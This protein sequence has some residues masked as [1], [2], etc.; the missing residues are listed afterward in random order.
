[1]EGAAGASFAPSE[2]IAFFR[3]AR[4][5]FALHA[6]N[7]VLVWG[8]DSSMMSA[9]DSFFPGADYLDMIHLIL[10]DPIG[11]DGSFGDFFGTVEIFVE[12]FYKSLEEKTP[13]MLSTAVSHYS[14]Q[15]NRHFPAEA[16]RRISYIYGK[17]SNYPA[18][19]AIVYRN[20][21]D[22]NSGGGFYR[23]ND[24]FALRD[25]YKEAAS[26]AR[27]SGNIARPSLQDEFLVLQ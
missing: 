22:L 15:S 24:S 18:I 3:Q 13:L 26:F 16:A 8:F 6:P 12:N 11:A 21:N 14:L 20:Y 1:L 2:Y 19:R 10:Y 17:I 25:A 9:A 5:I 27:Y 23:I 4:D 7:A